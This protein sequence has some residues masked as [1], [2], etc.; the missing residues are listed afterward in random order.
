MPGG[1]LMQLVSFGAQDLGLMGNPQITFFQHEYKPHTN[2]FDFK[3]VLVS[4]YKPEPVPSLM[5]ICFKNLTPS[6][7]NTIADLKDSFP[8]FFEEITRRQRH[9][10]EK[11]VADLKVARHRILCYNGQYLKRKPQYKPYKLVSDLLRGRP[12]YIHSETLNKV[13]ARR[14]TENMKWLSSK[15]KKD[16]FR[17]QLLQKQLNQRRAI[18]DDRRKKRTINNEE[19][20]HLE[21][22]QFFN[23]FEA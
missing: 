4:N 12:Y 6:Q 8:A 13:H 20:H 2:S 5:S 9:Y 11:I 14:R 21:L 3:P 18:R 15:H 16:H 1:G 22:E 23:I 7:K 10:K 19:Y 17:K